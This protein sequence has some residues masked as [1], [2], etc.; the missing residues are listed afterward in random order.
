M[1]RPP[2]VP[3][4]IGRGLRGR[5]CSG[6]CAPFWRDLVDDCVREPSTGLRSSTARVLRLW[7]D[8]DAPV[9]EG[10]DPLLCW[11]TEEVER[12]WPHAPSGCSALVRGVPS[13]APGRLFVALLCD[14][15]GMPRLGGGWRELGCRRFARL[16]RELSSQS[17][18]RGGPTGSSRVA[19]FP[20][21][22]CEAIVGGLPRRCALR[23]SRQ[24]RPHQLG[25]DGVVGHLAGRRYHDADRCDRDRRISS[26]QRDRQPAEQFSQFPGAGAA[27]GP[28]RR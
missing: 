8:G 5:R 20:V 26:Q 16:R 23:S 7:G 2:G 4:H 19:R 13:G 18:S 12:R 21:A 24:A 1:G 14:G 10:V 15:H 9:P 25:A 27:R 17:C 6:L 22:G 28:R 3:E 11:A